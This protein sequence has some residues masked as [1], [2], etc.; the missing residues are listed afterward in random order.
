MLSGLGDSFL[1]KIHEEKGN[2]AWVRHGTQDRGG[3]FLLTG[4][5]AA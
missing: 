1:E 3:P 4:S 2:P 5:K